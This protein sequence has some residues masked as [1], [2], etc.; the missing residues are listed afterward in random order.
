MHI[1]ASV[2]GKE[3]ITK[4]TDLG[5]I[6]LFKLDTHYLYSLQSWLHAYCLLYT[7]YETGLNI[8]FVE[9]YGLSLFI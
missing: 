1:E 7:T 6:N 5:W 4:T 2:E 9:V 8:F 3:K